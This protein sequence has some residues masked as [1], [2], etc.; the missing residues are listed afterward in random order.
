MP[1]I[2]REFTHR[3]RLCTVARANGTAPPKWKPGAA[4]CGSTGRRCFPITT[5]FG[6]KSAWFEP[7]RT[8]LQTYLRRW[9]YGIVVCKSI[10]RR[11]RRH[12]D[13]E[14][15]SAPRKRRPRSHRHGDPVG[16]RGT[17]EIGAIAS[18]PRDEFGSARNDCAGARSL[19]QARGRTA[20]FV[21]KS[22]ALLRNRIAADEAGPGGCG[23]RQIRRKARHGAER[24]AFEDPGLGIET[25]PVY[26][27]ARRCLE[28]AGEN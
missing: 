3:L 6:G 28:V 26:P 7:R 21:R 24:R 4:S 12:P 2:C 15:A 13:H 9:I 25:E 10:E 5:S 23:A 19:S 1:W 18:A 27:G 16:L 22:R 11:R 14:T 17:E 8:K 20:S